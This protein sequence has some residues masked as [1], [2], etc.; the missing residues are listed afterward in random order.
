MIWCQ[1]VLYMGYKIFEN[2]NQAFNLPKEH[3]CH[4]INVYF[5]MNE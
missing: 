3:T 5:L 2:K 1:A 4:I